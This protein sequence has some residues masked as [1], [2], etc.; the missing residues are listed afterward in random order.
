M[1]LLLLT[2]PLCAQTADSIPGLFHNYWDPW[3]PAVITAISI[4][5]AMAAL[6]Y[7]YGA[8]MSDD[9]YKAWAKKE[10]VEAAYSVAIVIVALWIVGSLGYYMGFIPFISPFNTP[11]AHGWQSYVALRCNTP[12]GATAA[13]ERPCHIRLAEDYL[14]TLASATQMQAEDILSYYAPLSVASTLG[15]SVNAYADPAGN[16]G[17]SPFGGLSQPLETLSGL[18]DIATKNLMSL[19]FQQYLLDFLHVAFFPLFLTMGLFFRALY[20]TRRLGGLLIAIALGFYIVLPMTYVFF[21]S[22]LFSMAGLGASMSNAQGGMNAQTTD[23]NYIGHQLYPVHVVGQE[24]YS[25][26]QPVAGAASYSPN[27]ANGYLDPGEECNEPN[28]ANYTYGPNAGKPHQG[29]LTCPPHVNLDPSQPVQPGREKDYYCDTNSCACGPQYTAGRTGD[30]RSDF[31]VTVNPV[32]HAAQLSNAAALLAN[33]C[34]PPDAGLT[35]QQKAAQGAREDAFIRSSQQGWMD[36]VTSGLG[37]AVGVMLAN[38][39][40]LGANGFMDNLAKL[41]IFS[42]IAPFVGIMASLAGVKALSPMLGGDVEIA[43]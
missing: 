13:L 6:S 40:L 1:L 39:D 19:R 21:Y 36:K 2:A 34:A 37:R 11:D 23:P 15:I 43:G 27:C 38:D 28:N 4:G 26:V 17:I 42:L 3:A 25:V 32:T 33:V 9:K 24:A 12:T 5:V 30:F 8:A 29:L 10:L 31:G 18:F 35:G 7:M 22:A 41:L 20:F 14:Q 16:F